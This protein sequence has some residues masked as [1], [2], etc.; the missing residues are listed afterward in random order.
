VRNIFPEVVEEFEAA[1]FG[2]TVGTLES[3][4]VPTILSLGLRGWWAPEG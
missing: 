1:S 4:E 3:H 2:S